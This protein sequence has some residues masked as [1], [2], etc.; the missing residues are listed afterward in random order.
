MEQ[1]VQIA[2]FIR[3]VNPKATNIIEEALQAL[4]YMMDL[5][6][7]EVLYVTYDRAE[8]PST[9]A[10]I[11]NMV[12]QSDA[13]IDDKRRWL[14][15]TEKLSEITEEGNSVMLKQNCTSKM[16]QQQVARE[17]G[18]SQPSG[19]RRSPKPDRS[20]RRPVG[21]EEEFFP[22]ARYGRVVSSASGSRGVK[23]NIG[24]LN[25]ADGP[26]KGAGP[27]KEQVKQK[28][29]PRN[30]FIICFA[31][32]YLAFGT[33]TDLLLEDHPGSQLAGR[34]A[35]RARRDVEGFHDS[36]SGPDL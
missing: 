33:R 30:A 19:Y 9:V 32:Y 22:A 18:G 21:P 3:H 1:S 8:I 15:L 14:N 36:Q 23:M 5:M 26:A 16:Q 13:D 28:S 17:R 2:N 27:D 25:K 20:Q 4:Y 10:A 7:P 12:G 6:V 11:L 24:Q 35:G 29:F 31:L 34:S